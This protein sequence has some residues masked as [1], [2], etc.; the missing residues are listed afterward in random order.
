MTGDVSGE[1][2]SRIFASDDFGNSFTPH[3][4]PFLPLMQITYNPR[5]ANILLVTS[6]HV[7]GFACLCVSWCLITWWQ[8][9]VSVLTI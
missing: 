5:D 4:L 3:D 7:G 8:S 2:G 6:N 1:Q 9:V